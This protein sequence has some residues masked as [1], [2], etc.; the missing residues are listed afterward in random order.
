[1]KPLSDTDGQP[2]Q[3]ARTANT[4]PEQRDRSR[5]ATRREAIGWFDEYPPAGRRSTYLQLIR[6]CPRCQG[7]LGEASFR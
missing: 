4:E 3:A 5:S 7:A 2:P 6:R 1:M